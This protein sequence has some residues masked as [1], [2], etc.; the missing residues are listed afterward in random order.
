MRGRFCIGMMTLATLISASACQESEPESVSAREPAQPARKHETAEVEPEPV[1]PPPTATELLPGTRI[2]DEEI[3]D[4]PLKTQI[5]LRVAIPGNT[6]KEQLTRYMHQLYAEQMARTGF[7]ARPTPNAVYAFLYTEEVDWKTNGAGWVGRIAK[8]AADGRPTFDNLLL[9]GPLLE[10]CREVLDDTEQFELRASGPTVHI[11]HDITDA[12]YATD[13]PTSREIGKEMV[14]SFF[15]FA[16][17]LYTKARELDSTEWL[18]TYDGKTVGRINLTRASY[19]AL[20][21][22]AEFRKAE[23]VMHAAWGAVADGKLSG[24]QAQAREDRAFAAAYRRM[25]KKLPA[26]AVKIPPKYRP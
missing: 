14:D 22:D 26:G 10:Q 12:Y 8:A 21:T 24:A 18:F 1:E 9:S 11:R 2:L 15:L 3:M 6:T 16:G 25:L 19:A 13:N 5:S 23:N 7:K 4:A 17:L 20:E